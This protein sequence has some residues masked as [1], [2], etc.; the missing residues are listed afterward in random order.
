[1]SFAKLVSSAQ[2][3]SVVKPRYKLSSL[4]GIAMLLTAVVGIAWVAFGGFSGCGTGC[5]PV[6]VFNC[7]SS[8][9]ACGGTRDQPFVLL[10]GSAA[11]ASWS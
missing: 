9:K 5:N 1:M 2:F 6:S 11:F 3:P 4:V 10:A 8:T 7:R